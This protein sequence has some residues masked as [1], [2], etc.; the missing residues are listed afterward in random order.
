MCNRVTSHSGTFF[1][2][3]F[4]SIEH[5]VPFSPRALQNEN[6]VYRAVF[7][8]QKLCKVRPDRQQRGGKVVYF[9]GEERFIERMRGSRS[10]KMEKKFVDKKFLSRVP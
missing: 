8:S 9:T 1:P 6:K 4:F 2:F 7:P 3:H 5:W 10:G